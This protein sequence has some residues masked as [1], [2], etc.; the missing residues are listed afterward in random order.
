[1]IPR[2]RAGALDHTAE[3]SDDS[4]APRSETK[5]KRDGGAVGAVEI[6]R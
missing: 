5:A 1:L 2:F 3:A 6:G 4:E